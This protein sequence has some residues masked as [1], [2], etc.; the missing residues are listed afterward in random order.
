MRRVGTFAFAFLAPVFL[1]LAAG[2][3]PAWAFTVPDA[4]APPPTEHQ[5]QLRYAD[6]QP[7]PYAMRYTDE[8]AQ[9]LGMHDGQWEA[10][11]SHAS[12]PVRV[13]G[14]LDSGRPMI[15]LQWRPGQ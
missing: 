11:D 2:A 1:G 8:A 13:T 3:T 6:N 4:N 7:S 10:F 12:D 5:I 15:S 9:R 14:G